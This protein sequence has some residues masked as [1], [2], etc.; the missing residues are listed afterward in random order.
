MMNRLYNSVLPMKVYCIWG[1]GQELG[2][3]PAENVHDA[4]SEGKRIWG[5]VARAAFLKG[6]TQREP[7]F[8]Q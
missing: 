6:S 3:L 7:M 4:L 8:L 2:E 1:D 5:D